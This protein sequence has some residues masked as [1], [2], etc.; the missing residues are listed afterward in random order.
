MALRL[1]ETVRNYRDRATLSAPA[2]E[3]GMGAVRRSALTAL[4]MG[5]FGLLDLN[6]HLIAR[7]NKG[8][9]SV[10]DPYDWP[11]V[12]GVEGRTPEI[13][14]E[15][16]AYLER[17]MIPLV[18]EIAGLDPDSEEGHQ[19]APVDAGAWRAQLLFANGE[20]V[21]E[22]ARHFPVTRSCFQDLH[23]KANVGFSML[24]PH[25]HIETHVGPNRGALRFQLPVVVPGKPGDCRI[26][27]GEEMVVWS[28]GKAVVFDLSTNH[29]A[30][31]DADEYRVL[32]MVEIAQPLSFPLSA[33]NRSAQY[34]YRWHPSYRR[35]NQ[36]IAGLGDPRSADA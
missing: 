2:H 30:W 1:G 28:E 22:I 7:F 16:Q 20:W 26:R 31:N 6:D 12:E 5:V 23:P 29:E 35:M 27:I 34:A 4:S 19:A 9:P 24:E 32:L 21:E 8:A 15:F 18:A 33:V 3:S 14:A 36:R 11:W 13:K 10:Y 17:V 25:S